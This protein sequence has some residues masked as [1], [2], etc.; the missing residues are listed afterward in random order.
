MTPK[1]GFEALDRT[2]RDIRNNNNCMGG[3]AIFLAGDFH[4]TLPVIPRGTRADEVRACITSFKSSYLW[5]HISRL[6]F[7]T[8]MRV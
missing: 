6:C 4:Q 1:G 8:N 7:T 2:L 5:P 3:V